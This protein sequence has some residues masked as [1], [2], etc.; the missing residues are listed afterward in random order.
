MR[1]SLAG[2]LLAFGAG[3]LVAWLL[4]R[5]LLL[6]RAH[7]S[8]RAAKPAQVV[9]AGGR[10]GL[11]STLASVLDAMLVA[12]ILVV[13]F[14]IGFQWYLA[15]LADTPA[16][17]A[18][19]VQ[20][21]DLVE[22]AI[23][24][25]RVLSAKAWIASVVLLS[26]IWL[27]TSRSKS[28]RAWNDALTAR[29]STLRAAL[30]DVTGDEL[31]ARANAVDASGVAAL[32]RQIQALVAD[33][34]E[35]IEAKR[36]AALRDLIVEARL[37]SHA[38]LATSKSQREPELIGEWLAAGATSVATVR[39]ISLLGRAARVGCFVALFIGCVGLGVVNFG[40]TLDAQATALEL[41]LMA[42]SDF[43][44]APPP[45]EQARMA[46]NDATKDFLRQSF[47][48]SVAR[49]LEDAQF[50]Q[51]ARGAGGPQ[52]A[53]RERFELRAIE[54][55]QRILRATSRP[56]APSLEPGQAAEAFKFTQTLHQSNEQSAARVLDEALDRR[57]ETLH[58]NEGL[59]TRL[60]MAAARPAPPDLV[61]DAILWTAFARG[62]VSN[63]AA[64]RV[65][66]ERASID[67]AN[68]TASAGQPPN[69]HY[70][71]P[72]F[73]DQYPLLTARDRRLV[74]DYRSEIPQQIARTLKGVRD[75]SLDPGSLH[76]EVPGAQGAPR[77]SPYKDPYK[78][79]FPAWSGP[80]RRAASTEVTPPIS[81]EGGTPLAR[82]FH[83]VR[84]SRFIK[85]VV[86]GS[87][88]QSGDALDVRRFAWDMAGSVK[89]TLTDGAGRQVNLGPYHPAIVHHALAYAAD[90][91]VVA[92]TSPRPAGDDRRQI[93]NQARRVL[94][95]PAFDDTP[96]ACRAIQIDRFVDVFTHGEQAGPSL[97]KIRSA[98]KAIASLGSVLA[99]AAER[100]E[101]NRR[102]T[103]DLQ[104]VAE[105]AQTCSA[106]AACF[107]VEHYSN[108]SPKLA[109]AKEF[110][111][112][113]ARKDDSKVRFNVKDGSGERN[114]SDAKDYVEACFDRLRQANVAA[115]IEGS[116]V[117][118]VPFKLD[119]QMAFLT[120]VNDKP[121]N[122][123]WP[124]DFVI[125]AVPQ[126]VGQGDLDVG[127]DWKLWQFPE[128]GGT[129][130]EAVASGIKGDSGARSVFESMRDFTILQRLFR[131]ALSGDL[132]FDFPL[133][134]LAQMQQATSEFVKIERSQRWNVDHESPLVE[135]LSKQFSCSE[136]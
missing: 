77:P 97:D 11:L 45:A 5:F 105:Y 28:R 108:Y 78:E 52:A 112:C 19:V 110:L 50:A 34:T 26:L 42:G 17:I 32:E 59:W 31:A 43:T 106:G 92:S 68:Q 86:I 114:M 41:R 135:T 60:R 124:L 67:F 84:F 4:V 58:R 54:A 79:M 120:G 22:Q 91:R 115:F 127:E 47:R 23:D 35:E 98:R 116:G 81:I 85:G 71:V 74:A 53:A 24:R 20:A 36:E 51:V 7:R 9:G 102:P 125:Q 38:A 1:V 94:V 126:I 61:A 80:T 27:A 29:R 40:P 89:L 121:K 131:V 87:R 136:L 62:D 30:A 46:S 129:I 96:F 104:R 15:G 72:P 18:K 6:P 66:A 48:T 117:R 83:K 37:A 113:L 134:Q 16:A 70:R 123:L 8:L 132:G 14:S 128:I 63:S 2:D 69:E 90:G 119:D 56:A 49:T 99:T 73:T 3:I 109:P 103:E 111:D 130:S 122:E 12:S 21:R 118:E 10:F 44:T 76:R 39:A 25:L 57:I 64:V 100:K 55:R 107:P 88:P 13:A 101:L 133:E 93:Q 75:G 82:D 95:H 65:W 33:N